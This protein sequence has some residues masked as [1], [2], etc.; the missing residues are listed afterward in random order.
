M[1]GDRLANLIAELARYRIQKV[2]DKTTYTIE[3]NQYGIFISSKSTSSY[4]G[5]DSDYVASVSLPW[6]VV[7]DMIELLKREEIHG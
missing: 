1:I 3:P 6:A 5:R 4:N 7:T 2:I